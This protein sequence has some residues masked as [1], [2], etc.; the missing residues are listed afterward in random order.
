M[1]RGGNID[2]QSLERADARLEEAIERLRSA[3]YT[4][5]HD[6]SILVHIRK[7][8]RCFRSVLDL[9][10]TNAEIVANLRTGRLMDSIPEAIGPQRERQSNRILPIL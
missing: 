8:S 2:L 9:L 3:T 5:I 1:R 6:F 10:R 7:L 4:E